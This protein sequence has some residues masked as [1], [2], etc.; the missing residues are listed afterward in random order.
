[1]LL[2]NNNGL[3][4]QDCTELLRRSH[5][6]LAVWSPRNI[7]TWCPPGHSCRRRHS[8]HFFVTTFFTVQCL[9]IAYHITV[10]E[11]STSDAPGNE[12]AMELIAK[13]VTVPD[14]LTSVHARM[15]KQDNT[16]NSPTHHRCTRSGRRRLRVHCD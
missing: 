9:L 3:T 7:W 1:M 16:D 4:V 2:D 12:W 15:R 14:V 8:S 11:N 13:H 5:A 6:Y 10:T